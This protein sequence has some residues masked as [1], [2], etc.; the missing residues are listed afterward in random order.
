MCTKLPMYV[1][2][3]IALALA[4]LIFIFFESHFIIIFLK[5]WSPKYELAH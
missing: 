2:H 1:V 4:L 3:I 5:F